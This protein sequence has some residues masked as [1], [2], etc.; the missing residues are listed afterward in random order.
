M[1]NEVAQLS[2]IMEKPEENL[3]E[4]NVAHFKLIFSHPV[5]QLTLK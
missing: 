2:V 3:S 1:I 5:T 4:K